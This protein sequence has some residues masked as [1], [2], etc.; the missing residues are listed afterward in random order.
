MDTQEA[1]DQ[2]IIIVMHPARPGG[3]IVFSYIDK[4]GEVIK[5]I[6]GKTGQLYFALDTSV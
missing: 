4:A 1:K 3:E 2:D 5:V 6:D